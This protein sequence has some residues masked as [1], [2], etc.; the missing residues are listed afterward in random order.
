M[1][2]AAQSARTPGREVD[3]RAG[4]EHQSQ[5]RGVAADEPGE[6]DTRQETAAGAKE[7]DEADLAGAEAARELEEEREDDEVPLR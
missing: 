2:L 3:H 6:Q 5:R 1:C 4:A 7:D